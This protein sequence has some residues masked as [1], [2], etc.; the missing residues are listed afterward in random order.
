MLSLHKY[1]KKPWLRLWS[2]NTASSLMFFHQFFC[3]IFRFHCLLPAFFYVRHSSVSIRPAAFVPSMKIDICR[4][5]RF[6]VSQSILVASQE[7][8]DADEDLGITFFKESKVFVVSD[9][10][11]YSCLKFMKSLESI[12]EIYLRR[13]VIHGIAWEHQRDVSSTFLRIPQIC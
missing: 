12:N 10:E 7:D 9:L 3:H 2:N 4:S 5:W 1:V 11:T 13:L 6:W 8:S